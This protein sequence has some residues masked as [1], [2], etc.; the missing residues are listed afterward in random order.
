MTSS[1]RLLRQLS[2]PSGLTGRIILRL[3]NR[4]N[5]GMNATAL[6]ALDLSGSDHVLEIGFGGGALVAGMLKQNAR[7]TGMEVSNLA[8]Q[9]AKKKFHKSAHTEFVIYS[10]IA[11]PF[12]D[13]VFTKAVCVN[14]IYFWKDVPAI[15]AEVHRALA[16][17]GAFILCYS[18]DSPDGVTRF[19][20]K[21]VEAQLLSAGF[22][23]ATSYAKSD[24][25]NDAY[26][27]TVATKSVSLA[28]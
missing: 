8:I 28:G 13:E 3:L 6:K 5:S 10:G 25:Q 2:H 18:E 17:H 9:T 20:H 14:V 11:F 22:T 1:T 7:V 12:R 26:Y 23:T 19:D 4:V 16:N 15:M 27:C 24:K 21:A